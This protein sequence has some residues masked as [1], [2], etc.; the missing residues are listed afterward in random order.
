MTPSLMLA[1]RVEGRRVLVVGGGKVAQGRVRL[2]RDAGAE[3]VVVAPRLTFP[4]PEGVHWIPRRFERGDLED[5]D[6]LLVAID[7]TG[8]ADAIGAFARRRGLPVNVA[9]RPDACDF[10]FPASF[11]DGPIQVAVSTNGQSPAGA[12]RLKRHLRSAMPSGAARAISELGRLRQGLR[13]LPMADRMRQA[14]RAARRPWTGTGSITLVGAGPGDPGLMTVAALDA[15]AAADLVVADRLVPPALLERVQAE[16]RIARK[17]PGRADAAQAELHAWVLEAAR[18]GRQVVR[19]KCG[20]PYL[21][22]RGHEERAF[23]EAHGFEVRVVPGVTSAL[24]APAAVGI[25]VTHRGLASG[26]RVMTGQG[27]GGRHVEPGAWD[28][29]VTW[30]WLMAMGRLDQLVRQL[31]APPD[32][33]VAIVQ[34]AWHPDQ[35]AVRA[36]LG[37][38]AAVARAAGMGAPATVIIGPVVA[39]ADASAFAVDELARQVA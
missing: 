13:R 14:S 3:I 11:R 30:I 36:P 23:F 20:D 8:L 12:A 7:D 27:R 26:V 38:I 32:V 25:P 33:P 10:W 21:Y 9:D 5:V 34:R 19:L 6:L 22:G 1:W 4:L 16:V 31:D 18:A 37:R 28:P 35:R 15:L 17:W 39:L 24:S 2:A 29:D